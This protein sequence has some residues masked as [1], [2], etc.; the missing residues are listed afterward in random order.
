M[1]L[2]QAAPCGQERAFAVRFDRAAFER[3]VDALVRAARKRPPFDKRFDQAIVAIRVEFS[4]PAGEPEIEQAEIGAVGQRDRTRI[5]QPGVVVFGSTKRMRSAGAPAA[6]SLR[7]T[8]SRM[9]TSATQTTRFSKRAIAPARLG[10]SV[11]DLGEPRRPVGGFVRPSND[12]P[13]LRF[14]FRRQA[15]SRGAHS[16]Q[17]PGCG[18][19]ESTTLWMT[20]S[21]SK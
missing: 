7:A 3:P 16:F 14:P 4:A 19:A 18:A 8:C 20:R 10:V 11:L 6:A 1:T 21:R 13:G 15:K 9:A 5:T 2:M 12:H 17:V